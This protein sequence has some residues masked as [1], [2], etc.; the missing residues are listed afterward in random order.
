MLFNRVEAAKIERTSA[1]E[2]KAE[3]Q[4]AIQ[5]YDQAHE[6]RRQI[7]EQMIETRHNPPAGAV[8]INP[9]ALT[10]ANR[11]VN[12]ARREGIDALEKANPG[13]AYD[14]TNYIFLTF[15]TR[16]FPV[17]LV[18]LVIAAI[19]AAAMSTISA[20][21]NA[22]AST[23]VMDIYRRFI[24]R[25]AEDRHYVF[26]AKTA[27]VCWGIYA[28]V[29]A[30]FGGRLGSLIEAVNMVGSLFYGSLLGVFVL[31]FG[32]PRATGTGTFI[33]LIAGE[34]AVLLTSR[35]T[36][37]SYLWFN[38]VGCVV[39]VIIGSI[40]SEFVGTRNKLATHGGRA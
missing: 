22:L 24:N 33:G 29:F 18:G 1:V 19:F 39:V 6:Q 32:F 5:K 11:A 16:Y 7:I 13:T 31:A 30:F 27:T 28:G 34:I 35:L 10:A 23:T 37:I 15:V 38:V 14:D 21:L 4:A 25:E 36:D 40:A 9:S 12:D 3:Y 26:A 8:A 20:E 2:P 17:G